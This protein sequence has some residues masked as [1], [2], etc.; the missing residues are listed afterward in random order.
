MNVS[1]KQSVNVSCFLS[2]SEAQHCNANLLPAWQKTK[3]SG[4]LVGRSTNQERMLQAASQLTR[5]KSTAHHST[6]LLCCPQVYEALNSMGE[7]AWGIN[8]RLLEQVQH[9]YKDLKG[10]FCGL[11][12]HE[13]VEDAPLPTQPSQLFRTD[14]YRGQLSARVSYP[15]TGNDLVQ[16]HYEVTQEVLLYVDP[17]LLLTATSPHRSGADRLLSAVQE[18]VH[19]G[20]YL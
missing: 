7:T 2:T 18:A 17:W 8:P 6:A 12:L 15:A 13:S 19:Y 11:P 16:D 4:G 5:I 20:S 3:Q 1:S 10:G 14:V 9:A